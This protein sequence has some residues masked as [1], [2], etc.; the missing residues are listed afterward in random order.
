MQIF[1]IEPSSI[2][3]LTVVFSTMFPTIRSNPNILLLPSEQQ[4][5]ENDICPLSPR[6]SLCPVKCFRPAPVCGTDGT[7]YWCGC[8]DAQCAGVRVKKS[9]FCEVGS[10]GSGHAGQALLLVHIVWL[11]FLGVFVLFGFFD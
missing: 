9:G 1:C 2:F 10:G 6:P 8:A 4:H 7:T 11:I 3:T 5:L